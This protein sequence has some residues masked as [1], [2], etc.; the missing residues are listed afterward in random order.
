MYGW[1][2]QRTKVEAYDYLEYPE[3]P[4]FHDTP[5]QQ[6]QSP[7]PSLWDKAD[8]GLTEDL[9]LKSLKEIIGQEKSVFLIS[10]TPPQYQGWTPASPKAFFTPKN[11]KTFLLYTDKNLT[12]MYGNGSWIF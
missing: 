12:N 9:L 8:L 2:P 4:N 5:C 7:P 1:D 3:P 6:K 10:Q 11:C